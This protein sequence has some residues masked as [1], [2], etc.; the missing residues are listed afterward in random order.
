MA[1][2]ARFFDGIQS[3]SRAVTLAVSAT[4]LRL[5]PDDGSTPVIWAL[6]D[7]MI[8]D[9]HT[10]AHPARLSCRQMPDARLLIET[11]EA[12]GQLRPYLAVA[13]NH[14]NMISASWGTLGMYAVL[15]VLVVVLAMYYIPK[16][17]GHLEGLVPEAAAR[18]L[19][20]Q[21]ITAHFD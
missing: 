19:G 17:A 3:R 10:R 7:I 13:R 4:S 5:T 14:G 2:H 8:L 9:E 1:L 21:V 6:G 11:A 18:S 16:S 20:R 15:C 12:W